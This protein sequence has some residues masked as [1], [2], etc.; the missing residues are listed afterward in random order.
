MARVMP[1]AVCAAL[2]LV[3][4]SPRADGAFERDV[5]VASVDAV[6]CAGAPSELVRLLAPSPDDAV[7]QPDAGERVRWSVGVTTGELYG[8]TA[9]RST[10]V[11]VARQASRHLL[12]LEASTFGSPVYREQVASLAGSGRWSQNAAVGVKGFARGIA[13]GGGGSEWTGTV[14]V[15]AAW[16][17]GGRLVLGLSIGNVGHAS[18]LSSRVSSQVA[19]GATLVLED[20]ALLAAVTGEPEFDPSP[21]FGCELVLTR[22]AR[23]RGGV[24]MEPASAGVGLCLSS[25]ASPRPDVDLAWSWHPVLGPS[26]SLTV[27][28]HL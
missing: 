25:G 2:L 8:L 3:L 15:S 20:V 5:A 13:W 19:V 28:V 11:T 12:S 1:G 4:C 21:A 17:V 14:D 6:C 9:L 22:W 7:S 16:L 24:R 23:L 26:Y 18:V 27:T 10:E